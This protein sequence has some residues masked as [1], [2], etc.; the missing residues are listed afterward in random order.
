MASAGLVRPAKAEDIAAMMELRLS[1]RQSELRARLR[2]DDGIRE[3]HSSL[4][5]DAS[6]ARLRPF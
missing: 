5:C 6:G 2:R 3:T 4:I 1:V